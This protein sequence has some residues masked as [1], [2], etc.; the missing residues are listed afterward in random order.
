[1]NHTAG[2]P[3]QEFQKKAAIVER[4]CDLMLAAKAK[5]RAQLLKLLF[6]ESSVTDELITERIYGKAARFAYMAD[7][8]RRLVADTRKEVARY[9]NEEGA[10]DECICSVANSDGTSW[11]LTWEKRNKTERATMTF[12]KAHLCH[13]QRLLVVSN[14]LLFFVDRHGRMVVRVMD[15]NDDSSDEMRLVNLFFQEHQE[16]TALP[17]VTEERMRP[18]RIYR[19]DGEVTGVTAIREWFRGLGYD[20]KERLS[21]RVD[22][23]E[24]GKSSP[25]LLGN[26]RINPLMDD[27]FK[28]AP[29]LKYR[30]DRKHF[31]IELSGVASDTVRAISERFPGRVKE[32][33][34]GIRLIDQEN[35]DAF[36]L[37]TRVPNPYSDGCVT[38]LGT[39]YAK[40]TGKTTQTLTNNARLSK[41]LEGTWNAGEETPSAFQ[42]LVVSRNGSQADGNSGKPPEL[43]AAERYDLSSRELT[44]VA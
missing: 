13:N 9:G 27:Q 35:G 18:M 34:A 33:Q 31:G 10:E 22:M 21:H 44:I 12:W 17:F 36:G 32:T 3:E 11:K 43:V 26:P 25:I 7:T 42:L 16:F 2:R 41:L 5:K 15:M 4:I 29:F 20:V 8:V 14:Q 38:M 6:D 30:M 24:L 39:E 40:V 23:R 1:M 19:L 28:R 37:T